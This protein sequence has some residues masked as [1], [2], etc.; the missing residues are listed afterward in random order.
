MHSSPKPYVPGKRTYA[1]WTGCGDDIA[2]DDI[3]DGPMVHLDAEAGVATKHVDVKF[4]P[5]AGRVWIHE[6][7]LMF[8]NGGEGDFM[9]ADIRAYAT[10]LQQS[11]AL[12]LEL[13]D[14]GKGSNWVVFASGGP[15]TGT[16]GFNG[17]PVLL[18]RSF[19]H[20]GHWNYDGTN[21]TPAPA[22][23][24]DFN[25]CD[26]EMIVHRYINRIPTTGSSYGYFTMSS[27]ETTELPAGYYMRIIQHNVSDTVW[28]ASVIM[29]IY[30]ERTHDP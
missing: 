5:D 25:I 29:E 13:V 10:P 30:R 4:L 18:P 23:D 6:G 27:N 15:G 28:H 2:G 17:T 24:G 26:A 8:D 7:Y 21:L 1:V 16:H 3:G 14:N 22:Q 9:S 20:D 12:D 11:V 19:S